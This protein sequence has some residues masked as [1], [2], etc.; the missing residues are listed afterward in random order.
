MLHDETVDAT[1]RAG[2]GGVAAMLAVLLC[3]V[4]VPA[5]GATG[6]PAAGSSLARAPG[7]TTLAGTGVPGF[8]GDGRPAPDAQLDAPAGIAEDA[9]G[10]VSIPPPGTCRVR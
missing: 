4:C 1:G 9:A 6:A 7:A 10:D 8:S 3:G 5:Q 2:A